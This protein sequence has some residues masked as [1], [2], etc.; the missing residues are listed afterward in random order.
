MKDETITEKYKTIRGLNGIKQNIS[1]KTWQII[2]KIFK[3]YQLQFFLLI[4]LPKNKINLKET[5][6]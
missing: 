5:L 3:N 1:K 4:F 2:S 6:E